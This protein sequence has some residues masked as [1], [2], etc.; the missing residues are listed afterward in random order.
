MQKGFLKISLPIVTT[1]LVV[2]FVVANSVYRFPAV[3]GQDNHTEVTI[4]HA[5]GSNTNPYN[6]VTVDE[7]AVD[8]N[9]NGNSD[10][11]QDG[12]QNGEDIIPPGSWDADGRNWD[13]AHIAIYEN[14]CD[15]VAS[16]PSP[17][18]SPHVSP[19][20]SVSPSPSPSPNVEGECTTIDVHG[21]FDHSSSVA[22]VTGYFYD[23]TGEDC[24]NT[25]WVL[26]YGTNEDESSPTFVDSQKY[27]TSYEVSVENGATDQIETFNAPESDYCVLQFD[28]MDNPAHPEPPYL[29]TRDSIAIRNGDCETFIPSPSPSPSPDASPTPSPTGDVQVGGTSTGPQVLAST[30]NAMTSIVSML[31]FGMISAGLWLLKRDT[32]TKGP[33]YT[34]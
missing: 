16:S 23:M 24:P 26:V 4:C 27:I 6:Q 1:I 28:L 8:G 22:P 11:N 32:E 7:D 21:Y 13:A 34:R 5:T 17:S 3:A 20:P 12:H 25:L 9:G 29:Y 31:G 10:H 18:P 33:H 2:L 30:G 19:T 14:D 15:P